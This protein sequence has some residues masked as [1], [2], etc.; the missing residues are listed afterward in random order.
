MLKN[1]CNPC[2]SERSEESRSAS[3]GLARFL[4]SLGRTDEG[5]L[6]ILL[7]ASK[8]DF[9]FGDRYAD[10]L[11]LVEVAGSVPEFFCQFQRAATVLERRT[12]YIEPL[13]FTTPFGL[14]G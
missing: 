3:T 6:S 14:K 11:N 2:R 12:S 4:A 13:L 7:D 5:F 10:D 9:R 8:A 1:D